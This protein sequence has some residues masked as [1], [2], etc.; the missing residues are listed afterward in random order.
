MTRSD[1]LERKERRGISG[2][3]SVDVG[4]IAR[5]LA[6]GMIMK[7]YLGMMDTPTHP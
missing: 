5:I 6:P 3:S 4:E 1:Q 7:R 2:E